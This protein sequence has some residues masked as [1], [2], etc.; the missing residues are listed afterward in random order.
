[1]H[2]FV[3]LWHITKKGKC[4]AAFATKRK[5]ARK[6]ASPPRKSSRPAKG[7]TMINVIDEEDSASSQSLVNPAE[8]E[9]SFELS[10]GEGEVP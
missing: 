2:P 10:E 4:K 1:M 6:V 9:D 8:P 5:G 3:T 7:K